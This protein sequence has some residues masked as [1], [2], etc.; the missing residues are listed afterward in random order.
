M[1]SQFSGIF[2]PKTNAGVKAC[3]K[4]TPAKQHYISTQTTLLK[5]SHKSFQSVKEI[6][7]GARPQEVF[8][9]DP[10]ESLTPV[11]TLVNCDLCLIGC[12]T[13]HMNVARLLPNS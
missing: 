4:L 11:H 2:T 8:W 3:V 5:A 7:A 1:P 10:D 6:K 9:T 13:F 12:N